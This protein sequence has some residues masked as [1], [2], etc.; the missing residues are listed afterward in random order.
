MTQPTGNNYIT[1][2]P[3][4]F[5]SIMS[6]GVNWF[7]YGS[8]ALFQSVNTWTNTNTFNAI[9]TTAAGVTP[10]NNQ[11]LTT[12]LYVD[13]KL[14]IVGSTVNNYQSAYRNLSSN[15]ATN[16]SSITG[17][18]STGIYI[19]TFSFTFN[20]TGSSVNL[21]N[22]VY[23]LSNS[24]TAAPTGDSVGDG[25][26]SMSYTLTIPTTYVTSYSN[27]YVGSPSAF[28]GTVYFN[29]RPI[30]TGGT[31]QTLGSNLKAV[32]LA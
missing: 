3:R 11:D 23:G 2:Y 27:V 22:L 31:F 15:V 30:F 1:L 12:K 21:T 26:I 20:A 29:V 16:L 6:D 13:T 32:R 5:Y 4:C 25:S 14:S 18:V 17:L 28:G 7:C 24:S 9:P 10:V 19:F 8:S